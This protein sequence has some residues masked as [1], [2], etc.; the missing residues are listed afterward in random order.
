[1]C[2][3][4]KCF[5]ANVGDSRALMSCNKG[6]QIKNLSIDH[7]P[8]LSIEKKRIKESGGNIYQ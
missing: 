3:D 4:K 2:I 1:M 6:T 5:I 8:N 7:K